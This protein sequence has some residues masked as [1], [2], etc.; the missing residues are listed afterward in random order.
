MGSAA[1]FTQQKGLKTIF[2]AIVNEQIPP[3]KARGDA[4]VQ[5]LEGHGRVL[6][7]LPFQDELEHQETVG[8]LL[9]PF[10]HGQV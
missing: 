2:H 5:L 9:L 1:A 4:Q 10:H 7:P 8:P 3:H 6:T